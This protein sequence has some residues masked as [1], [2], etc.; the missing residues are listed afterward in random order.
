M[1]VRELFESEKLDIDFIER[2]FDGPYWE[3]ANNFVTDNW[4][5]DIE[6]LSDKQSSWLTRIVD[7]C[8]EKRIE[9]N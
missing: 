6:F 9:S 2:K 8:V 3:S 7:D 5:K 1:K 4:D